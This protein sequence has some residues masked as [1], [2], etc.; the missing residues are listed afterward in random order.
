MQ[1]RIITLPDEL[2]GNSL[3]P[4]TSLSFRPFLDYIRE[5]MNNTGTIKKEIYQLILQ[6]FSKYP[7]LEGEINV[8]DTGKYKELLDLLYIALSTVMEDEKKVLWG[9]SVPVTP[10]IFYGSD[11]LYQ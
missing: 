1:H 8:G 11:P 10:A 7:E 2:E 3:R 6:K 9:I 5:R 4:A